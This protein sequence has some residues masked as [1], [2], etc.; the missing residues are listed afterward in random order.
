MDR[1]KEFEKVFKYRRIALTC[2]YLVFPA[3]FLIYAWKF[4]IIIPIGLI[5]AFLALSLIYWRCPICGKSF[6]L[7]HSSMDKITHCPFCGTKLRD[8]E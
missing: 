2:L 5:I 1:E 6:E 3:A 4:L 8:S 7:R